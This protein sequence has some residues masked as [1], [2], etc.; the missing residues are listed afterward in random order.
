MNAIR[1]STSKILIALIVGL[2]AVGSWAAAPDSAELSVLQAVDQSWVKAYNAGDANA[3][4]GLYAQDAVLMPPGAPAVRGQNAIRTFFVSDIA[5]SKKAGVTFRLT[6]HPD[7]GVSGN[8]GW[9][10]GTYSVTD[11][12]GHVVEVGKYLSVSRKE[13]G[14]WHYVRDTWNADSSPTPAPA[15]S[16]KQ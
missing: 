7:G 16:T 8:W 10:S 13:G 11:K 2:I 4:A 1:Q 3:V 14:S 5:E 9:C 6:G 15:G 12:A